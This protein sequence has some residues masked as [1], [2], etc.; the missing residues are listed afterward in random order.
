[1]TFPS[2]RRGHGAAGHMRIEDQ[3]QTLAYWWPVP[4]RMNG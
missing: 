4:V 3:P 1:V 2:E